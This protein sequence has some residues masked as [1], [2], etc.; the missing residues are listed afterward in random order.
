MLGYPGAVV[1]PSPNFRGGRRA[2][3]DHVV[4]HTTE[5]GLSSSLATL[6]DPYRE[7]INDDGD[8]VSARVS[9][10][11]LVSEDVIYQL[12]DDGDE[13]WHAGPAN[14]HTIG[15]EVVGEADDPR[16]WSDKIVAQLGALVGWLSTEYGIPLV[17][18]AEASDPEAARGFVAHGALDP[19]RRHDP[20]IWFPWPEVRAAARREQ[21]GA[22]SAPGDFAP[23][24]A[25]L[26]IALGLAWVMR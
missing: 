8:T 24:V 16:T 26:L 7:A 6:T 22:P 20:G 23:V 1:Q 25:L 13:A 12:V 9:A 11:Y 14:R 18:R 2:A 21:S 4:L 15:V 5:G 17:Y 3:V 10:H 19:E